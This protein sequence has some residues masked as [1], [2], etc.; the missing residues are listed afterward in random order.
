L[1][2][3][4]TAKSQKKNPFVEANKKKEKNVAQERVGGGAGLKNDRNR[5]ILTIEKKK[6]NEEE[7][8][9]EGG[10]QRDFEGGSKTPSSHGLR[11]SRGIWERAK[12]ENTPREIGPEK[13]VGKN[14]GQKG[15][16]RSVVIGRGEGRKHRRLGMG[17]GVQV[18]VVEKR[19]RARKRKKQKG[20]G[21][22]GE[23][24][25]PVPWGAKKKKGKG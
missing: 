9:R 13:G 5:T 14:S 16:K 2:A 24:T 18:W 20:E 8:K 22:G 23:I 1:E 17:G 12:K 15:K 25:N 6:K 10:R 11:V 21:G 19:C 7:G 4:T 3:R